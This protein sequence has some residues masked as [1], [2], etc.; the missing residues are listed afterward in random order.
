MSRGSPPGAVAR[1]DA[2]CGIDAELDGMAER[3]RALAI[4]SADLAGELRGY[5]ERAAS[6]ALAIDRG[7][8]AGAEVSL[9]ILEERLAAIERVARKHG[10]TIQ[11]ALDYAEDARA[12]HREL[13]GRRRRAGAGLRRSSS[14]RERSFRSTSGELRAARKKAAASLAPGRARAARC[15]RDARRDVRGGAPRERARRERRQTPS[16]S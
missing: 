7:P 10:G 12:R 11:A 3:A 5:C 9:D 4:E 15:A 14:R 2:V 1:L 6:G 8:L 16:S 13:V